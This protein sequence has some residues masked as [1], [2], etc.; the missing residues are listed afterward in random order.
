MADV[1]LFQWLLAFAGALWLTARWLLVRPTSRWRHIVAG[2]ISTLLWL[3]VAY[4]ANNVYIAS[5]GVVTRFGSESLGTFAIFMVVVCIAALVLG[6]YLWVE[7]AADDASAEL[8]ANMR[9]GAPRR[10]DD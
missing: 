3:P 8:P 4:T 9:S 2:L 5:S 6:L 7:E 1:H 10:G